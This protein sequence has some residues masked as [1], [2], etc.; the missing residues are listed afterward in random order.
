MKIREIT[1]ILVMFFVFGLTASCAHVKEQG[2]E[3]LLP[4]EA[5][6]NLTP[7]VKEFISEVL[8]RGERIKIEDYDGILLKEYFTTI[9]VG[10][11]AGA[12]KFDK[13]A[14]VR[15]K[16][17]QNIELTLML[18]QT[19]ENYIKFE[20]SEPKEVA[21]IQVVFSSFGKI[22]ELKISPQ[23]EKQWLFRIPLLAEAFNP[24]VKTVIEIYNKQDE[25]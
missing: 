2:P 17:N 9:M 1:T 5:L 21:T 3:L 12:T 11:N 6:N 10:N 16:E 14:G 13:Y 25:I 19:T 20:R 23:D 22:Q 24:V 8:K 4:Q 18:M 7:M 15:K